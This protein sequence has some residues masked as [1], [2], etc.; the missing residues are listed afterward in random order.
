MEQEQEEVG[1]KFDWKNIII[2]SWVVI[3]VALII[4]GLIFIAGKSSQKAST[5]E[6]VVESVSETPPAT[7]S[8]N[9]IN[10]EELKKEDIKL[11]TGEEAK[12][13]DKVSVHYSGTLTD[14]TKFD[15]S[16][17]RGTP[18]E[19]TIGEGSVI[20]GWEIGVTGMKVGGKRKLTIPPD[21]GYGSEG[22]GDDI[23]PN[24]TLV[25]EI[26]LLEIALP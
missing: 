18:F 3:G 7:E 11:G 15:S 9:P 22:A 4:G 26:E 2:V 8:A 19:F 10:M 16:I 6:A 1:V 13:G 20:Q 23:P 14:G 24:S 5:D 17:D 25:F 21:L 12:P